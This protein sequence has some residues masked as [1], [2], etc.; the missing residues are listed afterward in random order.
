MDHRDVLT[1]R[2][3]DCIGWNIQLPVHQRRGRQKPNKA[4]AEPSLLKLANRSL[5]SSVVLYFGKHELRDRNSGLLYRKAE[6]IDI[7]DMMLL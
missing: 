1:M 4:W 2:A 6:R 5:H 7:N 3:D